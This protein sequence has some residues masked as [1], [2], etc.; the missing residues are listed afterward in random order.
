VLDLEA[1]VSGY[2]PEVEAAKIGVETTDPSGKKELTF[3]PRKRAMTVLDLVR[4]T[5]GI[6]F[7]LQG[8]SPVHSFNRGIG[9]R[10]DQSL[11]EFIA[12]IATRPLAYQPG[13]DFPAGVFQAWATSRSGRN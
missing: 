10:R 13:E 7:S 11:G 1:P 3:E 4:M 6:A 2:L 5:S 9:A 12:T 8:N